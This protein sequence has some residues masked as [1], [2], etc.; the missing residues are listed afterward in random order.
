LERLRFDFRHP[1]KLTLEEIRRVE[2]IVKR[3]LQRDLLV[4][5]GVMPLK[6]VVDPGALALSGEREGDLVKVYMGSTR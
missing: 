3:Q 5:M 4:T 1:K 2:E 6:S